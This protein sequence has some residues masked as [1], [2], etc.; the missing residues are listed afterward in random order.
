MYFVR[1]FYAPFFNLHAGKRP[2]EPAPIWPMGDHVGIVDHL[3]PLRKG[4]PE[5]V[6]EFDVL[7]GG[8]EHAIVKAEVAQ[9][10]SCLTV[11]FPSWI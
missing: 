11:I 8:Y 10:S 5:M 4:R 2:V 7:K 9:A 3:Q 6:G 1:I